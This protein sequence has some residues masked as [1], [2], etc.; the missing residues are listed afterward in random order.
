LLLLSGRSFVKFL[1]SNWNDLNSMP[2]T[3]A[4]EI[5]SSK[6]PITMPLETK[7]SVWSCD[8]DIGR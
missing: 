2:M 1:T 7:D 5:L 4:E 6:L 3:A 8:E